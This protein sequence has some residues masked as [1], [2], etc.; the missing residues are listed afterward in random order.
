MA[1]VGQFWMQDMQCA[2]LPPR[3]TGLPSTISI[4]FNGQRRAHFPASDALVRRMEV[5]D[6][7][8]DTTPDWVE[9][10]GDQYLKEPHMAGFEALTVPD[11][12]GHGLDRAGRHPY[13]PLDLGDIE[14]RIMVGRQV[15]PGH[16]EVPA[17][18]IAQAL[19]AHDIVCQYAA[20]AG[21]AAAGEDEVGVFVAGQRRFAEVIGKKA[22]HFT[23]ICRRADDER[24]F[25]M[26]GRM[27]AALD[28]VQKIERLV[29]KGASPVAGQRI[30]YC[31]WH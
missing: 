10:Q 28:P 7:L 29:S 26:D 12:I 2:Q 20:D 27:V 25:R 21:I 15:V 17:P 14:F 6:A 9:G 22:R 1:S 3:Q 16:G 24:F 18:H 30:A 11:R 5:A 8:L 19:F 31:L 13:S 23:D 4:T